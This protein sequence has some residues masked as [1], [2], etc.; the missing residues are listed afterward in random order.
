VLDV[1]E[2]AGGAK[3]SGAIIGGT[4]KY[5]GATGTF[6]SVQQGDGTALDTFNITLP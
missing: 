1:G 2:P 4:G 6:E 5:A 3:T